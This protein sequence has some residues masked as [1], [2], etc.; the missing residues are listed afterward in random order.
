MAI[1][2]LILDFRIPGLSDVA[3]VK[4]N[5]LDI[6]ETFFGKE[7]GAPVVRVVLGIY[8]GM[9]KIAEIFS[10]ADE[11]GIQIAG[12]CVFKIK[13]DPLQRMICSGGAVD[14]VK[15]G[16]DIYNAA[17]GN[18][19]LMELAQEMEEVFPTYDLSG[20]RITPV[21][22][23]YRRLGLLCSTVF[24]KPKC[25]GQCIGCPTKQIE[26]EC[27]VKSL[28]CKGESAVGVLFPFS[29]YDCN[30]R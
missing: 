3:G 5:L 22:T 20:Q 28:Q 24:I 23:H 26:N 29:K 15:I 13:E 21:H 27:K 30:D 7:C 11:D 6:A 4:I 12:K 1:P 8:R 16:M 18:R 9:Q 19:Q 14:L 10:T 2:M 17:S 25:Y